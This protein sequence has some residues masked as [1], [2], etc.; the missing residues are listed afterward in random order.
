MREVF[1]ALARAHRGVL[2][3]LDRVGGRI[4]MTW[5]RTVL[6]TAALVSS[7]SACS[8]EE[9][10]GPSPT[11]PEPFADAPFV[12]AKPVTNARPYEWQ[13]AVPAA[14]ERS[15]TLGLMLES[16]GCSQV[17]RV[18]DEYQEDAVVLTLYLGD[19]AGAE[20]S[21]GAGTGVIARHRVQPDEKLGDRKI[22]NG[23]AE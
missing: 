1:A 3:R 13:H 14:D 9:S 22:V 12:D 18:E 17:A 23:D 8:S 7:I 2:E 15:V 21:G 5:R 4:P 19:E 20:C 10:A 6:A 11:M 16:G